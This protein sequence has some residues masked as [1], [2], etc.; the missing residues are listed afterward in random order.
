MMSTKRMVVSTYHKDLYGGGIDNIHAAGWAQKFRNGNVDVIIYDKDDLFVEPPPQKQDALYDYIT[1]T[2]GKQEVLLPN[3]GG[4]D[5]SFLYHICANYDNLYDVEIF[6]KSHWSRQEIDLP[7]LVANAHTQ[8]CI[9]QGLRG[10]AFVILDSNMY[11]SLHKDP[12][13]DLRALTPEG[14]WVV[15]GRGWPD[16]NKLTWLKDTRRPPCNDI[17]FYQ[18]KPSCVEHQVM[19]EVFPDWQQKPAVVR[20]HE[21]V[22]SVKKEIIKFHPR[23]LYKSWLDEFHPSTKLSNDWPIERLNEYRPNHVDGRGSFRMHRDCWAYFWVLFFNETADR[24]QK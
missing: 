12:A 8:S 17:L 16:K 22:F 11:D 7:A 3:H 23:Q 24:M 10:R 20:Q 21:G 14:T 13:W 18:K 1:P 9:E 5:F 15:D 6:T 2:T 4:C 19:R